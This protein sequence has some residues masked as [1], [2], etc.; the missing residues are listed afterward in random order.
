M[1]YDIV[2]DDVFQQNKAACLYRFFTFLLQNVSTS[3]SK[4]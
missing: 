1:E 4:W 3:T 2:N